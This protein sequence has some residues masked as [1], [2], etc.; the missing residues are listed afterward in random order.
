MEQSPS[1]EAS[2]FS[3]SQEIPRILWNPKVHYRIHKCP[4]PY[5]EPFR[6]KIHFDREEL[7]VPCPTPKLEHNTLSAV[8]DWFNVFAAALHYGGRSSTRNLRTRRRGDRDPL[9]TVTT[10]VHVYKIFLYGWTPPVGLG[11][12]FVDVSHSHSITHAL[13]AVGLPWTSDRPVAESS[14]W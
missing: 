9:I 5:P 11:L 2:R 10:S 6:Y 3:S 13:H 7:L 1:W 4:L 12:P 14:T 8:R